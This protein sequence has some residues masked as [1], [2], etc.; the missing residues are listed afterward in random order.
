MKTDILNG[1]LALKVVAEKGN[2]TAAAADM[3]VSPSAISQ[4]IKQLEKRLEVT[5]LNRT[6]RSVSLTEVGGGFL[7]QYQPA[8]EQLLNAIEQLGS[9][10]GKP[11]GLLRLNLP[12][13]CWPGVIGPVMKGFQQQYP[14][15]TV[16]LHFEDSFVDMVRG[17]F[18]A[19]IRLSETTAE[20]M[21]AIRISPPLRFVVAGA[22]S[23]LKKHGKPKHPNDLLNHNCICYK[24]ADGH[25]YRRWEFEDKGREIIVETKGNLLLN[26]PL[27]AFDAVTKGLGLMYGT[28]DRLKVAEDRGEIEIVLEKYA[29]RSDGY[30]LYYP[31]IS[32]VSPKLRAFIEYMKTQKNI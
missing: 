6:S 29:A 23:Y 15:I 12:R 4:T 1:L 28:A 21:T 31:N 26:D 32:Q 22:P 10:S 17:G 16:E 14:D 27:I 8:L 5:L 2:F 9:T 18:D 24:F 25:V 3:G 30:Y 7:K 13:S 11:T 20:D 19:G